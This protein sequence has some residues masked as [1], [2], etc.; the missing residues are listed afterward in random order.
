MPV[1]LLRNTDETL[2]DR[3]AN[4]LLRKFPGL[5]SELCVNWIL[6][7]ITEPAFAHVD[8]SVETEP[9][10]IER[11]R[12]ACAEIMPVVERPDISLPPYPTVI[13]YGKEQSPTEMIRHNTCGTPVRYIKADSRLLN[14]EEAPYAEIHPGLGEENIWVELGAVQSI[15][16]VE[17]W[18]RNGM[19]FHPKTT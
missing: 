5:D 7:P 4:T 18:L 12:A 1:V 13:Y 2:R 16:D 11:I 19:E 9:G 15:C 8:S 14:G 3:I 10:E 17:V 6:E